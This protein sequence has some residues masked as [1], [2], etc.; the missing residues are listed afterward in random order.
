MR[1]PKLSLVLVLIAL[2][3]LPNV[4]TLRATGSEKLPPQVGQQEPN[5]KNTEQPKERIPSATLTSESQ[6]KPEQNTSGNNPSW[7]NHWLWEQINWSG[8][9]QIVVAGVGIYFVMQ[10][11]KA[12]QRQTKANYLTARAARSANRI[13][14]NAM[15]L[16]N[17]PWVE[18][19]YTDPGLNLIPPMNLP[20]GIVL[21]FYNL[22]RS[23]ANISDARLGYTIFTHGQLPS[24]PPCLDTRP[25]EAFLPPN[26]SMKTDRYLAIDEVQFQRVKDGSQDLLIFGYVDYSDALNNRYRYGYGWQYVHGSK[27]SNL[28]FIP[29]KTYN[30]DRK[31]HPG[32]GKDWK[33]I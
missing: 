4:G 9:G 18:V 28:C 6:P 30:Y 29:S 13:A 20:G 16:G 26:G 7:T 25:Q 8:I 12:I 2:D 11:L 21:T 33:A 15:I 17:R 1:L 14:T 27:P 19:K 5:S 3:L 24:D 32:E 10:T 23:P 22:G 31:R